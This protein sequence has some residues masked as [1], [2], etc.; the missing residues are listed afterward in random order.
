VASTPYHEGARA[1]QDRWDTRRLADRLHERLGRE[2]IGDE[3]RA[4]IERMDMF[5][6]ATADAQGRPQCSYKGGAPGFVRVLDPTTLAFPSY[7]GNGMFL[8]LGN[9]A[10]NPQVG[11]L[12]ID[13][14]A[15]RPS[16]LRVSGTAAIDERDPLLGEYPQAQLVVRVSV[17]RV[18]PNCP[19]YI[20]RMELVERSRFLPA[21]GADPPVPDWKRAPWAA[22]VLPSDDPAREG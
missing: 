21:A 18:F 3:D 11:M 7:D 14:R 6:L 9:L 19:R 22:D 12:F 4:F 13:F 17:D 5:F 20:H 2:A 16:R 10:V 15:E 8:S 1:L